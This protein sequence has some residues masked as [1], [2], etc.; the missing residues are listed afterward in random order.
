MGQG[1]GA[2]V[3][4]GEE[5]RKDVGI[6]LVIQRAAMASVRTFGIG[7]AEQGQEIVEGIGLAEEIGEDL[8]VGLEIFDGVDAIGETVVQEIA[9]GEELEG[10]CGLFEGRLGAHRRGR[11][12]R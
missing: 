2:I 5:M 12:R 1:W 6:V 10:G 7:V 8:V 11:G 4:E 9:G 3:A